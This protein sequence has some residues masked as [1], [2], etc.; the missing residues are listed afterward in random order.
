MPPWPHHTTF[1]GDLILD[2]GFWLSVSKPHKVNKASYKDNIT[3]LGVKSS[4]PPWWSDTL[5]LHIKSFTLQKVLQ[6]HIL[7]LLYKDN[8]YVKKGETLANVEVSLIWRWTR[9][10][11]TRR[12]RR[13]TSAAPR[14]PSRW[15]PTQ[16]W[17]PWDREPLQLPQDVNS[18]SVIWILHAQSSLH[19]QD[20]Y[21]VTYRPPR[22][23]WHLLLSF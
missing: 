13:P 14:A 6:L 12:R 15:S 2:W 21:N 23:E 1:L 16:T 5:N 3:K 17:S 19:L 9:T 7:F 22:L 8:T 11:W 10:W 4:I 18:K 20:C